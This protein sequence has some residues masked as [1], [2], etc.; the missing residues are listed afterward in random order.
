MEFILDQQAKFWA[1]LEEL[2]AGQKQLRQGLDELRQGLDELKDIVRGVL[3]IQQ[4][5]I[6]SQLKTNEE[7]RLLTE[8]SR[9]ADERMD[10]LIAVVNGLVKRDQ[11]TP[12]PNRPPN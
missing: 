4:T 11:Q 3:T 6:Q 5:L 9:R 1:G 10:A 2:R 7:L 12:P 8:A